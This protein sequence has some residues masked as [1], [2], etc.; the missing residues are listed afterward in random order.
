M[1]RILPVLLLA[2]ATTWVYFTPEGILGKAGAVGYA[3]CHRIDLRSFH[4]GLRQL[5]LCARC[6]GMYL[7]ALLGLTYFGLR[8]PKATR[9][10]GKPLVE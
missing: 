8:H 1:N 5:P 3:V 4:L 7:G 2:V 9:Y 10:P 6:T